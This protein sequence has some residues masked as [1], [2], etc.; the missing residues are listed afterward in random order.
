MKKI[1]PIITLTAI[2]IIAL[3]TSMFTN[4]TPPGVHAD[5]GN[6]DWQ[7]TVTGLVQTPL[8]LSLTELTALPKTTQVATLVCVDYPGTTLAEGNWTGVKLSYLLEEANVSDT[9]IK[10]A[11]HAADGYSTDL[12][13]ERAMQD[14]VIIAYQLNGQPLTDPLRLVVPGHWGYKWISQ[15]AHIELVD[16]NYLGRWESSG[17]SDSASIAAG[18]AAPRQTFSFPTITPPETSSPSPLPS[19]SST[20]SPT[21]SYPPAATKTPSPPPILTVSPSSSPSS[22]PTTPEPKSS[23]NTPQTSNIYSYT[24]ASVAVVAVTIAASAI[25]MRKKK[26]ARQNFAGKLQQ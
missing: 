1:L 26:A 19:A 15:L 12:T 22:S 25:V 10:V 11:F 23:S 17:Y 6:Q 16:Y 24:V 18:G 13:I 2:I 20:P 4:S 21:P 9:A 3:A 8:N 5:P 14:D 7:L